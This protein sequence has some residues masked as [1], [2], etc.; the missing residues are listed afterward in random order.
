MKFLS[1]LLLN[2]LLLFFHHSYAIE[3]TELQQKISQHSIIKADFIQQKQISG[4]KDPLISSG[5]MI[6]DRKHGLWWQQQTPFKQTI[7]ANNEKIKLIIEN[8]TP[9]IITRETQP[10][11]FQFSNLLNAI[12]STDIKIL[13]DNFKLQ[14]LQPN[15]TNWILKLTPISE[16]L[17]KIFE[18]I[19]LSGDEF[20]EVIELS[21][22]QNDK[23]LIEFSHFDTSPLTTEQ[24]QL[25][26]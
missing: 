9:Q 10:Q 5:K 3:M 12:F 19:I 13:N 21:D 23:T 6:L 11:L 25:F 14:I 4:L 20:L 8:E 24:Q 22:K 1:T 16:P 7:E 18:Q 15:Q 2:I 26:N 17:N